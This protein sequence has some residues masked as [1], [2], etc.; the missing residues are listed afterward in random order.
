M[1]DYRQLLKELPSKTIVLACGR[2]NPPSNGHE[3]LV[4]AVKKL[5]EQ[6]NASHVIYASNTS[7]AKK[8]PLV[9]EKK[10]QYLN[11][12][13][14]NT[15]FV[16]YSDL[17]EEVSKLKG[18][19]KNIIIVTS[20]DKVDSLKKIK[21]ATIISAG[22][23]DPDADDALRSQAAKGL[24][25]E[26][27][28][29]LPSAIREIDSR[30]L[31]NDIRI[32][33]RLEPIKEEL[34]LVKDEMRE[35]YFRGEIFNVGEIVES[36]GK[37]MEIVKRGSNH[38]LLKEDSG[39]LITKWVHNVKPVKE[40]KQKMSASEKLQKTLEKQRQKS[41]DARTGFSGLDYDEHQRQLRAIIHSMSNKP[42]NEDHDD[43][44]NNAQ[45]HKDNAEK[46]KA[47]NNMA[48]FHSHMVN[49]HDELGKWHTSKGR[50]AIADKEFEKAEHHHGEFMK[51][52]YI[53]EE[54][55]MNGKSG[56]EHHKDHKIVHHGEH[57]QI[58]IGKEHHKNI[59]NLEHGGRHTF[60]DQDGNHWHAVKKGERIHFA[61]HSIDTMT[62]SN[63]TFHVHQDEFAGKD[64][65]N[66]P[67]SAAPANGQQ[68]YD[69]ASSSSSYAGNLT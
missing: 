51:H 61:A 60:K 63:M 6:N 46:A 11:L 28:K 43:H 10:L 45:M 15:N 27:K 65:D 38:L 59:N 5:A 62:L 35:K 56:V 37:Q 40:S 66:G 20:S 41:K 33:S 3:L 16:E 58:K 42:V 34:K 31:M 69:V 67:E 49:H 13:F 19:Y 8:N 14:P 2:F 1:K 4:K 50:H 39:A 7:D 68:P 48:S 54:I 23:K 47:K 9:V 32:G 21:E 26:F 53:A 52:P 29:N 17:A 18:T 36:D 24:Y 12:L 64:Q 44:Y 57:V 22:D 25:E 30:R 55:E